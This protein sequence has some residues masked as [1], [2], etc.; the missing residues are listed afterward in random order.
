MLSLL[1]LATI[2]P[3]YYTTKFLEYNLLEGIGPK[4]SHLEP[5]VNKPR[6]TL[7]RCTTFATDQL[8]ATQSTAEKCA[9]VRL[10]GTQDFYQAVRYIPKDYYDQVCTTKLMRFEFW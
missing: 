6:Y 2:Q 9:S 4:P 10:W 1:N 8:H 7:V 3:F 5:V